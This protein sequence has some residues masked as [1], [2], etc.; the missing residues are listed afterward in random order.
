ML[1]TFITKPQEGKIVSVN[2]VLMPVAVEG[3]ITK[4]PTDPAPTFWAGAVFNTVDEVGTTPPAGA[5]P[6]PV[7]PPMPGQPISFT[8]N[9][10]LPTGL[11]GG[12]VESLPG[13]VLAAWA[14]SG[15]A[16]SLVWSALAD[17]KSIKGVKFTSTFAPA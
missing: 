6:I 7:A 1:R 2:P 16:G 10:N 12:E 5:L 3:T 15:A 17:V 9:V 13:L 11:N 4:L 14:A 8:G